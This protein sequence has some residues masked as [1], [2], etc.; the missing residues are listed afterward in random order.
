M[1]SP[2]IPSVLRGMG[3]LVDFEVLLPDGREATWEFHGQLPI[4]AFDGVSEDTSGATAATLYVVGGDY[5]VEGGKLLSGKAKRFQNRSVERV[6]AQH[7]KVADDFAKT[8][9]GLKATVAR[10]AFVEMPR[11][12]T[13]CARVKA[14][15][16]RANK[17]THGLVLYRHEFEGDA[18]PYLC[19]SE[20][21]RQLWFRGGRYTVTPHGIEDLD[22]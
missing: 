5:K 2:S 16:Y 3:D 1:K 9:G 19:V 10:A 8:H 4:L 17:R 13:R 7:R 11:T 20:T 22:D 12:L 21:G 6:S 14:V 18:R 15:T